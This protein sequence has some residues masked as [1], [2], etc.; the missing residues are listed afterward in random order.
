M[1]TPHGGTGTDQDEEPLPQQHHH[2]EEEVEEEQ[3]QQPDAHQESEGPLLLTPTQSLLHAATV[4]DLP[5][6]QQHLETPEQKQKGEALDDNSLNAAPSLLPFPP[7]SRPPPNL[8]SLLAAA[9]AHGQEACVTYLLKRGASVEHTDE[10]GT[11]LPLSCTP[12][13]PSLLPSFLPPPLS[14]LPV[15][16]PLVIHG[17]SSDLINPLSPPF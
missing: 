12:L 4:G 14:L 1:A 5:Y 6:L 9:A 17:H 11:S 3:Q 7:P 13:P 10:D 2:H 15:L 16:L 8:S